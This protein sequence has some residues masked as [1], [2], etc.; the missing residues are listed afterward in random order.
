MPATLIFQRSKLINQNSD[1]KQAIQT[2]KRELPLQVITWEFVVVMAGS[3]LTMEIKR[4][5]EG[6]REIG[7]NMVV[8]KAIMQLGS[9]SKHLQESNRWVALMEKSRIPSVSVF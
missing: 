6:E 9:K 3:S 2:S 4:E 1:H 7:K 5:R 8:G